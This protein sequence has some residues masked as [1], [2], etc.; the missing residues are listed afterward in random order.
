MWRVDIGHGR[1]GVDRDAWASDQDDGDGVVRLAISSLVVVVAAA[2][3]VAS[4]SVAV[5]VGVVVIAFVACVGDA[6]CNSEELPVLMVMDVDLDMGLV[7]IAQTKLTAI[8]MMVLLT[9]D[10]DDV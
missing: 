4:V 9:H 7:T 1:H 3:A 6:C 5:A 8:K 2:A 10:A